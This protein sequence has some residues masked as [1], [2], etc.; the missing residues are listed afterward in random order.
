MPVPVWA[1]LVWAVLVC[2][3]RVGAGSAYVRRVRFLTDADVAA[4]LPT[5]LETVALAREALVARASGDVEVPPKPA[6]RT[7]PGSFANAMPA[8]WPAR[9][10]LGCKWITIFPDNPAAGLPTG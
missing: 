8:A 5:P 9:N 10:L 6:V 3:A 2:P 4:L 1:V 7:V